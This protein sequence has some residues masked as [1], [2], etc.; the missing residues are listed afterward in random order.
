MLASMA[1]GD[2]FRS[3]MAPVRSAWHTV[4]G[5]A[6]TA[7]GLAFVLVVLMLFGL[8][9]RGVSTV[10]GAPLPYVHDDPNRIE[11]GG[12]AELVGYGLAA[13]L[14]LYVLYA[15]AQRALPAARA[16][17]TSTGSS[18]PQL[19]S[20]LPCPARGW[21]LTTGIRPQ[22]SSH[23]F[24]D[25]ARSVSCEAYRLMTST[26]A[27]LA[28]PGTLRT[29]SLRRQVMLSLPPAGDGTTG[30]SVRVD[31]AV[32]TVSNSG[33]GQMI[34]FTWLTGPLAYVG[35]AFAFRDRRTGRS[36]RARDRAPGDPR[37]RVPLPRARSTPVRQSHDA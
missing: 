18:V 28:G 8:V 2:R 7:S 5:F 30:R 4:Y 26:T 19:C 29:E 27:R 16:A 36:Q 20:S 11:W 9:V 33:L 22:P 35:C 14:T 1:R 15:F 32:P 12:V 10:V 37:T 24:A 34:E 21:R 3:L 13:A 31:A 17:A 23:W 25:M 6:A